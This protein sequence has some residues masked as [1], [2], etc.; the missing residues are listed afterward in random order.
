MKSHFFLQFGELILATDELAEQFLWR[1]QIDTRK[2]EVRFNSQ[3]KELQ[4]KA[5]WPQACVWL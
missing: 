4:R 3:L 1:K 5:E 2:L